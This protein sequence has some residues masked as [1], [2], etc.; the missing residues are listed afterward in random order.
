MA[1][2]DHERAQEMATPWRPEA[3]HLPG[4]SP[5]E[6]KGALPVGPVTQSCP[7]P[8]EPQGPWLWGWDVV[9]GCSRSHSVGRRSGV[10]LWGG[11]GWHRAQGAWQGECAQGAGC[12]Q[13]VLDPQVHLCL[14]G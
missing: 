12:L 11:Q 1:S 7:T 3:C 2:V 14:W 8:E 5:R 13:G 4:V 6:D 9:P 10:T